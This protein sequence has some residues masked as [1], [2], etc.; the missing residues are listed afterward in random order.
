MGGKSHGR[1]HGRGWADGEG[2]GSARGGDFPRRRHLHHHRHTVLHKLWHDR[3]CVSRLPGTPQDSD[4]I[5]HNELLCGYYRLLRIA[6]VVLGDQFDWLAYNSA[7]CIR[8]RFGDLCSLDQVVSGGRD[9]TGEW[10]RDADLDHALSIQREVPLPGDSVQRATKPN[11]FD[12]VSCSLALG[13]LLS[14]FDHRESKNSLKN[15]FP[16]RFGKASCHWPNLLGEVI[17]M[18][19]LC[20]PPP[21]GTQVV[22]YREFENRE[23]PGMLI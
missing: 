20:Q 6:F 2:P 23:T 13:N 21:I 16:V 22:I 17:R 7:L 5:A 1:S 11:I 19:F 10:L 8:S 14:R 18:E 12:P 9:C 3:Q 15:H 4:P